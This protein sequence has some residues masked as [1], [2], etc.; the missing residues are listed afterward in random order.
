MCE[1]HSAVN[2]L[3]ETEAKQISHDIQNGNNQTM[4]NQITRDITGT[5]GTTFIQKYVTVTSTVTYGTKNSYRFAYVGLI[6]FLLHTKNSLD[7]TKFQT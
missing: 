3:E 5:S 4:A 2:G 1:R 7:F 6:N